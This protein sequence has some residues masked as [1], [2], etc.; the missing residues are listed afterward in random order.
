M[1]LVEAS[2]QSVPVV[3]TQTLGLAALAWAGLR[4]KGAQ[5]CKE[6][7]VL[8]VV[9]TALVLAGQAV[10]VSVAA[11]HS[12]H[13]MGAALLTLLLGPAGALV[14]MFA[15]L[16]IQASFGDGSF[17]TL[18]ANFLAIGVAPVVITAGIQGLLK[19]K[20]EVLAASV[21]SFASVVGGAL[22]LAVIIGAHTNEMLANHVVIGGLEVAMTLGIFG[23]IAL[24]KKAADAPVSLKP[25][26]AAI[27]VFAIAMP[28]SSELPDGLEVIVEEV[29]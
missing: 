13:F 15:V 1:H 2:A 19:G 12:G 22:T 11:H 16:G 29:Q 26:A 3:A 4:L 5:F 24:A 9:L 17:A 8:A 20:N 6:R 18:G 14:S 21:G 25:I 27:A 28:F 7:L 23:V 10:N